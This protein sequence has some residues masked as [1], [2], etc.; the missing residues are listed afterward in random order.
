MSDF[1][2][3]VTHDPQRNLVVITAITTPDLRVLT[4]FEVIPFTEIASLDRP[5]LTQRAEAA[6][7]MNEERIKQ[8]I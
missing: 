7:R 8:R 2:H 4:E 5:A 3:Q 6:A 1:R